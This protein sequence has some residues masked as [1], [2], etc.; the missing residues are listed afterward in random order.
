MCT[1]G[2]PPPVT[3]WPSCKGHDDWVRGVAFSPD[4]TLIVS[5]SDD[6]AVRLW[7]LDGTWQELTAFGGHTDWVRGVAFSPDGTLIASCSD[8]RNVIL[9]DVP[10]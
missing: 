6:G 4:G 5:G 3:R 1:C 2:T 8:D 9:W 7:A 10:R